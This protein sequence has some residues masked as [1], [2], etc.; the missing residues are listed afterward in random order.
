MH[1][2][3]S[4]WSAGDGRRAAGFLS[5]G[6]FTAPHG[7]MHRPY[8][9]G[10]AAAGGPS[11]RGGRGTGCLRLS[12][13]E[14]GLDVPQKKRSSAASR[15]PQAGYIKSASTA[16]ANTRSWVTSA[17]KRRG[18]STVKNNSPPLSGSPKAFKKT[19]PP[20]QSS[21]R[22]VRTERYSAEA[23]GSTRNRNRKIRTGLKT[24]K[25]KRP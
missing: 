14:A 21:G 9:A 3:L 15:G 20:G 13:P 2:I 8:L 11:V 16:L 22:F 24:D 4:I 10:E 1:L 19:R 6:V 17:D 18:C 23:A 5:D 7:A 12:E 25:R